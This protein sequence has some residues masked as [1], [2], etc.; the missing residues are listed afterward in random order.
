MKWALDLGTTNS[1][2][3]RWS[4]ELGRAELLPLP[5][6]CRR[7]EGASVLE[8]PRMVPSALHMLE[9]DV[10]A[11]IGRLPGVRDWFLLGAEAIIGRPALD[12]NTGMPSPAFI[13]GFKHALCW[14]PTRPLARLGAA[15]Y[16]ARDA[17]RVFLRELSAAAARATGSRI[18]D[19]TVTV[20]VDTY[21]TYRAELRDLAALTGVSRL[22]FVD[23]PVAAAVGYGLG[24]ERAREIL[25]FDM[26]GGT[27]H[28]VRVQL[29]PR[30]TE[31]GRCEVRAKVG[32]HIGG[33]V[34]DSWLLEAFCARLGHRL[35]EAGD[36]GESLWL[37]MMLS[38]AR[39][40][41][42]RLH[43]EE[44][45][46]FLLTAPEEL[47]GLA[48]RLPRG[49]SALPVHRHDLVQI[50]SDHGLYQ[51]ID[52]SIT[53]VGGS[54]DEVLLVGGSTLLPGVHA[55]FEERFGRDRVR[56][57]Q[58]FESVVLG[59][60]AHASGRFVQSDLIVH[61]YALLTHD[62]RTNAKQYTVIIPRGTRFPTAP[63]LWRRPMVPT[64]ALGEPESVFKLEVFEIGQ[65]SRDA[66]RFMW[67]AGGNLKVLD[68]SEQVVVPLNT[69]NPVIGT[70]DPPHPPG[71]R[72][73]R[74]DVCFGVNADRWLIATVKDLK[75]GRFLLKEA[76]VARLM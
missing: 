16:T 52:A 34:V 17:A 54:P 23:E 19:L 31:A 42:E 8:A 20:P 41:K 24:V 57:W 65:G 70:L 71:E 59:A 56:A 18:R 35:P 25:V 26:G 44:Q 76:A 33:N 60:A 68:G 4:E 67:D 5:E 11:K 51:T 72:A 74:L 30:Q 58:P 47:R 45:A 2:L 53:E 62:A 66:K 46:T 43:F 13:P 15:R 10:W 39:R 48:A 75:T 38:E 40:V 21:D 7:A 73:P 9:P 28:T 29:E 6:L 63:D 32:R 3:A 12:R 64:C 49:E 55:L 50:L 14:E 22:R 36:E 69:A 37:A 61:D 1:A 27:M